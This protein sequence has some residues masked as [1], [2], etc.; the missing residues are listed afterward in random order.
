[1]QMTAGDVT[2][3]NLPGGDILVSSPHAKNVAVAR[4][5]WDY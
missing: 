3:D 1:M 4:M 2:F 5:A